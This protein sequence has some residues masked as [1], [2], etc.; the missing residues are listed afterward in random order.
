VITL[1]SLLADFFIDYTEFAAALAGEKEKEW[2]SLDDE[3]AFDEEEFAEFEEQRIEEI[4][5]SF[6]KGNDSKEYSLVKLF[7]KKKYS[8]QNT[9]TV[10]LIPLK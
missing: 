6:A 8:V 9:C 1:L 7:C 4:R 2:E 3:P 10:L 5:D